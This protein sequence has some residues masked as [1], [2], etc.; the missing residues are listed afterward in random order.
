MVDKFEYLKYGIS[1]I[2]VFVG[3]K[4]VW[5]NHVFNGKFPISISLAF[6]FVVLFLCILMSFIK[7]RK[8]NSHS[9]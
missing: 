3:I 1:V 9:S 6:I 2:L 7:N 5:L 4:M 8:N